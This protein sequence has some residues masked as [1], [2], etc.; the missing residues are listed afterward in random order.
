MEPVNTHVNNIVRSGNTNRTMQYGHLEPVNALTY[1][2][3]VDALLARGA[4][5][6]ACDYQVS[7]FLDMRCIEL[8]PLVF[9]AC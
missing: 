7:V 9:G 3:I 2:Q 8:T 1:K 6:S 4:D 5:V